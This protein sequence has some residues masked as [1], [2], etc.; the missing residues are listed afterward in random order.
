MLNWST[1]HSSQG[2]SRLAMFAIVGGSFAIGFV[3]FFRMQ[4]LSGFDLIFRDRGDTRLV[5]FIHEHV[6]RAMLGRSDFLSPPFFYDLTN[7]LSFSD[8]FLLNQI[9]YAPLRKLGADPYL[10]LLLT[11]MILSIVGFGAFYALLRQFWHVSV[12]TAA[13]SSF[14]FTFANNLYVNANHLQLFAIYYVPLVAYLVVCAVT[15]IHKDRYRSLLAGGVAGLLYALLFPTGFYI[16][17]F[18]GFAL[19]VFTLI[20]VLLSWSAVREWLLSSPARVGVLG[21]AFVD[22]F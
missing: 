1:K 14:L 22:G 5:V 17:W 10:A 2:I 20:F 13:V 16:A 19:F 12:T 8:A 15:W 9:M 6:Y 3:I 18:F 7:T 11:I 21:L 4:I